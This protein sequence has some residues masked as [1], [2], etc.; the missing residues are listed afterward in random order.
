M[1][2]ITI[3]MTAIV[4][5]AAAASKEIGA[6]AVKEAY[7]GLKTLITRKFS[8]EADVE[9]AI[10]S[11]EKRPESK[12]RQGVLKEELEAAQAAQDAD[13]LER[14]SALLD[15]L[16]KHGEEP[17]NYYRAELHGSGA[18][19]QGKDAKAIGE[20]GVMIDGNAS[21]NIITGDGNEVK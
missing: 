19:A 16:K 6:Q 2:P 3:I 5:G 12:N 18:I 20:R 13:I 1:D 11:V 10:T 9:R 4:A 17:Q 8:S 7:T 21:G 14:A 15:L